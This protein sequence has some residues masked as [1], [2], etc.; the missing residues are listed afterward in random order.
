MSN[1]E[2]R[3]DELEAVAMAATPGKRE[4]IDRYGAAS[5]EVTDGEFIGCYLLSA[6]PIDDGRTGV[7]VDGQEAPFFATFD[8]ETVLG[9]IALARRIQ[10]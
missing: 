9:L 2:S 8:R 10:R 5:L 4:W 1:I 6:G 7:D 3:L